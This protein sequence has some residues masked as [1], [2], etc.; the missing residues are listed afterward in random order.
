MSRNILHVDANA[1]YASVEQQR[2]PELRGKPIAVCGS[3][4]DRHGIVL[5]ASYP[6]KGRGVK[7]GMA[8]WQAKLQCPELIVV[9]P[10]MNEYIR[11][12]KFARE[13]YEDYTD[14]VEPFGLDEAWLDITGSVGLYG[15]PMEIAQKIS[16]RVKLELGITVSIGVANNK[17]TAKL[18][19]DYKKPDAITRIEQDNYEEIVYPLPIEDLLYVGPA[20]SKKLRSAGI[21]SIGDLA[22]APEDFLRVRLGKM[23]L[24]LSSFAKGLDT[25]PVHRTNHISSIK[26]IGNSSTTPRDLVNNEDVYLMLLLLSESVCS[27][28]REL[29]SKCTI[30]EISIRNTDLY[31][32]TR[33]RKL[34]V[35]TCSSLE[36]ADI[37][38]ELFKKN[39]RWDKPIRSIGV[40]GS[41]LIEATGCDQLSMF[42]DDTQRQKRECIDRTVDL[43]RSQYGYLSIQRAAIYADAQLSSVCPREH[44]VHPV[45]FFGT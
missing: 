38:M 41:G 6:A 23:G 15:S 14:Q 39:Y 5:T 33:Q 3:Q 17:V 37:A 24:I 8:I 34:L 40:R 31:S 4:E 21:N 1:F 16:D 29:V 43:I 10:D 11:I 30:V 28:M 19:S 36:M 32:F 45:G 13:I 7:T 20:T 25:T 44:I 35:P 18:G 42:F 27:R 2:H 26:S 9:P 12:S 22:H